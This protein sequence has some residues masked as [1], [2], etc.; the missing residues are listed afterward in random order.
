MSWILEDPTPTLV[1]AALIIALLILALVK[2]GRGVLLYAIAGVILLTA[3]ILVAERLVVTDREAISD[4]LSEAVVALE[5]NDPQALGK[6]IDPTS[7]M[8]R[9]AAREMAQVNIQ[10]VTF[11]RLDVK[12]NRHTSPATAEADF[13]GYVNG[14]DRRGELPYENFTGRFIVRFRRDG[15]RWL[16]TGYDIPNRKF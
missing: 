3:L 16:M 7:P 10:K 1:G 8:L 14:R 13:M 4:T 12:V 9:E 5:A 6:L 2:T 15:D 11:S